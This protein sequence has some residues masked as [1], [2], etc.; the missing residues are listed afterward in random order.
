MDKLKAI[1]LLG[2]PAALLAAAMVL[3]LTNLGNSWIL[4]LYTTDVTVAR[5]L[6][7]LI[8][9]AAG[10][11]LWLLCRWML[12]AGFRALRAV[13]STNRPAGPTSPA[14]GPQ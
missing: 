14:A 10:A 6:L 5:G 4:H 13:K 9:A 12:P 3:V 11:I 1:F 7:M 2:I 8:V